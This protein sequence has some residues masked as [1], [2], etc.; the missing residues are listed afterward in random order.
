[1]QF[2][3]QTIVAIDVG[4]SAVKAKA[5]S[6]GQLSQDVL[7][8]SAVL[9]GTPPENEE[10]AEAIKL[11][12]VQ[13]DDRFY[14]VGSAAQIH[15]G[16]DTS[17]GLSDE[18][19]D[20]DEYKA[21]VLS[22]IARLHGIGVEGLDNPLV[23]VG[24]PSSQ[25]AVQRQHLEQVTQAITGGEVKALAQPM[26]ALLSHI[27]NPAGVPIRERMQHADGRKKSWAVIEIGY[28]TTDFLV[29]LNGQVIDS[30]F[31]SCRGLQAA[32][33]SLQRILRSDE[34]RI[35]ASVLDCQEAL[36]TKRIFHFG[37]ID[38]STEVD[39]AI[40]ASVAEIKTKATA[41][42]SRNAHLFDQ[43]VIAGGG[44]PLIAPA[45]AE[46]WPNVLVLPNHRTAVVDGYVRYGRFQLNLRRAR[47]LQRSAV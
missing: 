35:K 36:R 15:G 9:P 18:W 11:D 43:I 21:L 4:R 25:I 40:V 7:F 39:K 3:E 10:T 28:Y 29:M 30:M 24:T 32:A 12:T 31:Q 38:V 26:G 2:N 6:S 27:Y 13:F 23:V 5:F 45:L 37:D 16:A 41:V 34:R 17:V 20:S 8:P 46:L 14:F 44:A 1:M 47:E 33:E 42:L 19:T 22:S